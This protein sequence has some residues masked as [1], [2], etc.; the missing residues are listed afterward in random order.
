[1]L[2]VIGAVAIVAAVIAVVWL[3]VAG[4]TWRSE[5][6]ETRRQLHD[7]KLQRRAST[8]GIKQTQRRLFREWVIREL[9]DGWDDGKYDLILRNGDDIDLVVILAWL[10]FDYGN[11]RFHYWLS[12]R[13]RLLSEDEK[14]Q[15]RYI[16]EALD[17]LQK[18]REPQPEPGTVEL[19]ITA[20]PEEFQSASSL[21][22]KV[23]DELKKR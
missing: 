6:R 11:L 9:V 5:M 23:Y 1:M 12:P 19:T 20:T 15:R 18:R 14:T 2:E 22:A 10:N 3:A 13:P 21:A 16:V 8:D 4:L 17:G 7:E